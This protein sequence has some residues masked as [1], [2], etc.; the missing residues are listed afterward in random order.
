MKEEDLKKKLLKKRKNSMSKDTL[1]AEIQ[2]RKNYEASPAAQD[3]RFALENK[4]RSLDGLPELSR[5]VL[6]ESNEDVDVEELIR[7]RKDALKNYRGF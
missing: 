4:L 3:A 5:P 6:D 1:M 7:A 2:A